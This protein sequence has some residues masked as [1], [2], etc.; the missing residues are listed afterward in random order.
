MA[1]PV[2]W[3]FSGGSGNDGTA[4]QGQVTSFRGA[5]TMRTRNPEAGQRFIRVEISG[6]PT[7]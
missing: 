7:M 6:Q 5:S 2:C 3:S 4:D 1:T